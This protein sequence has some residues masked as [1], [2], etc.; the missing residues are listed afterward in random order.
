[1][2]VVNIVSA[3]HRGRRAAC[4]TPETGSLD[5]CECALAPEC[6]SFVKRS[7]QMD[8]QSLTGTEQE[9]RSLKA[10]T[11]CHIQAPDSRL[12]RIADPVRESA[13]GPSIHHFHSPMLNIHKTTRLCS[14]KAA[15]W[16]HTFAAETCDR[17]MIFVGSHLESELRVSFFY[18]KKNVTVN[19][20]HALLRLKGK[21]ANKHGY[22]S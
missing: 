4:E 18:L 12:Y 9:P 16:C 21:I 10:L 20:T 14:H 2:A 19:N 5:S 15:L 13:A 7:V 3:G 22:S 6:I 8:S 17:V 1:M 11:P